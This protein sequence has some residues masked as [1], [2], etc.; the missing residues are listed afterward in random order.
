M[1]VIN[2]GELFYMR[3]RKNGAAKAESSLR[4]VRRSGIIVEPAT[5]QRVIKAAR[6]KAKHSM[7]YADA[8]A[9]TLAEEL[10]ATLVTGDLEYKPLE[11]SL[12]ILWI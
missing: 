7:S 5:Q 6:L 2:L 9:A 12:N 10:N 8:F 4:F 11:G 1:S 3:S